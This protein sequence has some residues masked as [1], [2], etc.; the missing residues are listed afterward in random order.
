[1]RVV[2]WRARVSCG[3]SLLLWVDLQVAPFTDKANGIEITDHADGTYQVYASSRGEYEL[4]LDA[5]K[6]RCTLPTL[7]AGRLN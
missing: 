3:S 2:R 4:W 5:L 7:G 6:V 1:M